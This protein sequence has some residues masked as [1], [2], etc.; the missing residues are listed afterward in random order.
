[1]AC[2]DDEPAAG[3]VVVNEADEVRPELED[4]GRSVGSGAWCGGSRSFGRTL[5]CLGADAFGGGLCAF[6]AFDGRGAF[7]G[8]RGVA[9]RLA[10]GSIDR[11]RGCG[12][13]DAAT[14][15]T[16]FAACV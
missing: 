14:C 8:G 16:A 2:E 11:L 3:A 13:D 9:G 1:M 12:D 15:D 4:D 5:G 6:G 10:G 7:G